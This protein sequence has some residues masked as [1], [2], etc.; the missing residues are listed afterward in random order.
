MRISVNCPS[1]NRPKVKTLAYLPFCNVWVAAEQLEDYKKHNK[2]FEDNFRVL[3]NHGNVSIARNEIIDR[4]FEAGA[5]VVCI[6]DDDMSGIYHFERVKGSNFGYD[7]NLVKAEDFEEFIYKHTIMAQDIGAYL[8][9]VNLNQDSLNYK[10]S[11]PISTSSII[12]GPFS[13]HLKGSDI[14]YDERIPLKEDYDLA[15]QHLNKYRKIL[16]MNKFHYSCK[17]SEQAGGCANIRNYT[18][19]RE[20]FELLQ[21]KWGEDIVRKD[22]TSKKLFDY[23]PIIKIPIKG[24]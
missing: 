21:R 23:N 20:Q 17:Q 11:Q 19:E 24:V 13:C 2:G 15:I 1:Y 12:L 6:I 16:R 14:R 7:K 22:K 9:G 18:S 4:E 3:R 8:W 5:D 10:H